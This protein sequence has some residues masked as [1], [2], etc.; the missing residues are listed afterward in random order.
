MKTDLG[1]ILGQAEMRAKVIKSQMVRESPEKAGDPIMPMIEFYRENEFLACAFVSGD[2]D[3]ALTAA[4]VG[5]FGFAADALVLTIEGY[6]R[7]MPSTLVGPDGY[8]DLLPN[9][10][11]SEY[12]LG[13]DDVTEVM[14]INAVAADEMVVKSA[15]FKVCGADVLWLDDPV[16]SE[17]EMIGLVPDALREALLQG[18]IEDAMAEQHGEFARHLWNSTNDQWTTRHRE[19]C[20]WS[21]LW[22]LFDQM[23]VLLVLNFKKDW[24]VDFF[25]RVL[26]RG[27]DDSA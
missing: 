24:E 21:T 3:V 5:A 25:E 19:L 18:S 9:Q 14:M 6:M 17:A 13:F 23:H 8:V 27:D 20:T 16:S 26:R 10:L 11:K 2:R 7:A 1:S 22:K 15:P 4:K 12:E